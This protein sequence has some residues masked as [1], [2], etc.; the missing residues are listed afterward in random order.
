MVIFG[1]VSL[2]MF[3]SEIFSDY[4]ICNFGHSKYNKYDMTNNNKS[5]KSEHRQQL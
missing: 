1:D 5:C 4:N 2:Y 3:Y